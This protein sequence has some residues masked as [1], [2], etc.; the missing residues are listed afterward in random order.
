MRKKRDRSG[1]EARPSCEP[2]GRRVEY[3]N[4][5]PRSLNPV[6]S[7]VPF[8]QHAPIE[9]SPVEIPQSPSGASAQC[10]QRRFRAVDLLPQRVAL[11]GGGGGGD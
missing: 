2:L 6:A 9:T 3:E 4:R 11:P 8:S 5:A 7:A 10:P 1:V